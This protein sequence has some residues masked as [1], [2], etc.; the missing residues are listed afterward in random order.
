MKLEPKDHELGQP[1]RREPALFSA[2]RCRLSL[3]GLGG[4][5]GLGSGSYGNSNSAGPSGVGP[6]TVNA[7]GSSNNTVIY[8]IL[9]VVAFIALLFIARAK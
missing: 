5:G 8:V 3:L 2:T 6:I 7:G 4:G 1:G 9:G